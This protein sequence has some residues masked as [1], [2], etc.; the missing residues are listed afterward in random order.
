MIEGLERVFESSDEPG[1]RE[2]SGLLE[3]LLRGRGAQGFLVERQALPSRGQRVFRLRFVIN[4]QA[5]ALVVKR[6]KP[7]ISRRSQLVAN[8]WLPAI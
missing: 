6:L 2:L 1:L 4:N 5:R 7:E 8:R 3:E